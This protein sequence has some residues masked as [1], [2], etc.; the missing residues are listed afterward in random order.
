[1]R[2]L[3]VIV[4]D[5]DPAS[6]EAERITAAGQA[7][8]APGDEFAAIPIATGPTEY[9]ESAVGLSLCVPGIL[10]A[11]L[12]HQDEFDA[13]LLGCFGDPGLRAARAVARIPVLGGA[14]AATALVR[15]VASRYGIVTIMDSDIP[16][17]AACLAQ[18]EVT[19]QCVGIR[20]VG[21]PFHALV[22]DPQDTLARAARAGEAL[23]A[24]G[25]QALLL[26]CMSFGPYPFARELSARL[27]VPVIDPLRAG[28]AAAGALRL[29]E[30]S[31]SPRWVPPIGDMSALTA[32]LA[33]LPPAYPAGK[34]QRLSS[35]A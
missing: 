18:M 29:L 15:L 28:V 21:L 12:A 7:L 24:A 35:L 19:Q 10:Q 8:M 17:I 5:L 9:Y 31:V 34:T 2:L 1:L 13:A 30:A 20:A 22:R 3:Y 6:N 27:G 11:I 16:E 4:D 32:H 26:G 25:A 23:L 14:E 33:G